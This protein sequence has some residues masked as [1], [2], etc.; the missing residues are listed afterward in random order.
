MRPTQ[1]VTQRVTN[2]ERD[3]KQPHVAE[4]RR[5]KPAPEFLRQ[6]LRQ[7]RQQLRPILRPR[8]AALLELDDMPSHAP[9]SPHLHHIHR[10]QDLLT[11]LS[12][13]LAQLPQQP[14]EA[15]FAGWRAFDLIGRLGFMEGFEMPLRVYIS[16]SA[17]VMRIKE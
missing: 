12:D 17:G 14:V 9:A 1:F 15:G 7:S 11:A 5:I 2:W 4:I 8:R 16:V 6:P 10:P 3:V 13:E